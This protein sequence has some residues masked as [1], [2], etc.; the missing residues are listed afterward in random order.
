MPL[1][2]FI[3][4]LGVKS[5]LHFKSYFLRKSKIFCFE[6][7]FLSRDDIFWGKWEYPQKNNNKPLQDLYEAQ[8]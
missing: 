6:S 3:G 5:T 8:L 1:E 2:V 4:T 7:G